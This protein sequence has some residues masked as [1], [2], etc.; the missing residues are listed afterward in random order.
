[1][2]ARFF[3]SVAAPALITLLISCGTFAMVSFSFNRQK[4]T[5]EATPALP[6]SPPTEEWNK[7]GK[8]PNVHEREIKTSCSDQR[9]LQDDL[10]STTQETTYVKWGVAWGVPA[11]M[12]GFTLAG[13]ALAI[14][15]HGYYMSLHGTPVGSAAR[16][17]WA[18]RFGT[19]F[20]FLS[21]ALLRTAC[22]VAYKQYIWT[23]FKR[24]AFSITAIDRLFQL[25][26]DLTAFRSWE[27]IKYANLAVALA[28]VTW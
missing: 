20:S 14:G 19:M 16:Q 10:S 27:L 21:I 5:S 13:V 9:L 15:H 8:L 17:N 11:M 22:N 28:V 25:T 2:S 12:V 3:L 18:L 1:L 4:S 6:F 26:N 7:L 23:L 24:K